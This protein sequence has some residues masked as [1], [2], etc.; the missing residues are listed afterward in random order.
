MIRKITVMILLI[1]FIGFS[2]NLPQ[3]VKLRKGYI[4]TADEG[5]YD[6]DGTE[7]Y[8]IVPVTL[9]NNTKNTLKYISWTCPENHG[10]IES[11]V[12]CSPGI[13][14]CNATFP[15]ID[16]LAPYKSKV[17]QNKFLFKNDFRGGTFDYKADFY[18]LDSAALYMKSFYMKST[19]K[20]PIDHKWEQMVPKK[21]ESN[22]VQMTISP[23]DW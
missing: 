14:V 13:I 6:Y 16:S 19:V 23:N 2:C 8:L 17:Y 3:P 9:T 18:L 11:R 12:L 10:G 22:S 7:H 21:L 4:L 15:Y 1:A 20:T 5:T